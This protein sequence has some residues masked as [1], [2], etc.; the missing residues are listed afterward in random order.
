MEGRLR[1]MK[2]N[3]LMKKSKGAKGE[4]GKGNS[5]YKRKSEYLHKVKKWGFEFPLNDKPW[6]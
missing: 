5:L 4:S 3:K 2:R 1:K 6:K